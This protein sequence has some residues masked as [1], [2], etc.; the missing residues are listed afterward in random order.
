MSLSYMD[1][2]WYIKRF[3]IRSKGFK[4]VSRVIILSII[5]YKLLLIVKP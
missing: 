1:V 3:H 4:I 2:C 5:S